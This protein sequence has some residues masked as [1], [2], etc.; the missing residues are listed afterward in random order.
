MRKFNSKYSK[1]TTYTDDIIRDIGVNEFIRRKDAAKYATRIMK[2]NV[3][4]KGLSAPGE[5]PGRKS[6]ET[7][8]KIGYTLLR[9]DRSA[10]IGSK[11]FK[12]H[13][14]EFG[15]GDGKNKNKRPF[16]FRSLREAEP[17]IIAIMSRE[18]F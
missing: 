6:G 1:L 9:A 10:M 18:Y 16:V 5:F 15:Q 14:L 13:L 12:V 7:F 17:G 8:R 3:N 2:K 11:S 4:R